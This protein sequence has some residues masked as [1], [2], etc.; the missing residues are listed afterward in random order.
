MRSSL[1]GFIVLFIFLFGLTI[2]F[3]S[4][5]ASRKS[6]KKVETRGMTLPPIVIKLMALEFRNIVADFLFVRVSQFYGGK[7]ETKAAATAE[8]WQWLYRNLD[9][10]TELDPYFQDPYYLG[11]GLLT[12]DAGM[13][14]EANTLLRKATDARTWD[15]WFPFLMGFNKFY[16]MGDNKGGAD[17]LLEASKRPGAWKILPKLAAR[18]YYNDARTENA[19]AFLITF[20]ENETD[21]AVKKEYEIRIEALKNIL[22]LEKAIKKYSETFG[23]L[24]ASEKELIS[25]GILDDIPKDPYGGKFYLGRDGRVMTTSKLAFPPA[26]EQKNQQEKSTQ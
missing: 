4:F 15:W 14:G 23:K 1:T 22:T 8:D 3:P 6:I 7:V 9:A 24:P 18:L 13:F 25:T 26:Q 5:E 11:N 19:I 10:I 17:A 2:T 20:W 12:W 16:F 21:E